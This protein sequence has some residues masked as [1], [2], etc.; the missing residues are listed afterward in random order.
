MNT[1]D[2][3][4][5]QNHIRAQRWHG[6]HGLREW[7]PAEWT[8]ALAGEVGELCNLT[9]KILR[10]DLGIQQL[11]EQEG[12]DYHNPGVRSWLVERAAEEIAVSFIYL[13]LVATRL[14]LNLYDIIVDKWNLTS[15]RENFPDRLLTREEQDAHQERFE[16][17]QIRAA[18][19][20]EAARQR[21]AGR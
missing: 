8:N 3:V 6:E 12:R 11:A 20:A 19:E 1:F 7:S 2:Y 5:E 14:G 17:Q 21:N 9:K 18:V 16:R 4:A 13:D 10:H 15:E